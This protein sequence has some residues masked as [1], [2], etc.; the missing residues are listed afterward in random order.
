MSLRPVSTS[1]RSGGHRL[2]RD[3]GCYVLQHLDFLRR[4]PGLRCGLLPSLSTSQHDLAGDSCAGSGAWRELGPL[5]PDI[6]LPAPRL[7]FLLLAVLTASPAPGNFQLKPALAPWSS[8]ATAAPQP[9]CR[10]PRHS[11][12]VP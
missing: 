4:G 11:L 2:L 6:E 10:G 7:L 5:L 12:S 8:E 9:G 1:C 3:A